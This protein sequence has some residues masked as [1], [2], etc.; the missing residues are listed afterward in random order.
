MLYLRNNAF[1]LMRKVMELEAECIKKQVQDWEWLGA[2]IAHLTPTWLMGNS[3]YLDVQFVFCNLMLNFSP[4]IHSVLYQIHQNTQQGL[5][6]IGG[7]DKMLQV[8]FMNIK[9]IR[10][11]SP[12]NCTN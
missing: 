6:N 3:S 10:K 11:Y 1:V 12:I 4:V 5:M 2:V 7:N 8:G 9:L